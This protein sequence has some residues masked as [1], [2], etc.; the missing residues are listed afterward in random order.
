MTGCISGF[1]H[2]LSNYSR[3]H[4]DVHVA[5]HSVESPTFSSHSKFSTVYR[6]PSVCFNFKLLVKNDILFRCHL[7]N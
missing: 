6:N 2:R 7:Q 1:F 3:D 5:N 4:P